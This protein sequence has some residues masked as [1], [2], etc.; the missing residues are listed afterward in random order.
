MDDNPTAH[1]MKYTTHLNVN[2]DPDT[3]DFTTAHSKS[4]E[5]TCR[6]CGSHDVAVN[7]HVEPAPMCTCAAS[8]EPHYHMNLLPAVVLPQ[9][10]VTK[11]NAL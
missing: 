10:T 9:G 7:T 4:P 1:S 3:I 2:V 11:E 8:L 5:Y 6:K